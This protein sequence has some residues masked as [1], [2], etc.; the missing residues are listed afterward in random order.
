[1]T[2]NEYQYRFGYKDEPTCEYG[3][4]NENIEHFLLKYRKYI[5]Q[6]VILVK[7]I[8]TGGMR[9]EKLLGNMKYTKFVLEFIR[10]TNRFEF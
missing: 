2:L 10:E 5:N 3:E 1:M 9:L 6:R 8:G 7:E 4:E